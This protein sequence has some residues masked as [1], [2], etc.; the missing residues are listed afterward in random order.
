VAPLQSIAGADEAIMATLRTWQLKPQPIPIC[1][2]SRFV[3]T[4]DR[5]K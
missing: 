2:L 4:V 3:F 1:S 5:R